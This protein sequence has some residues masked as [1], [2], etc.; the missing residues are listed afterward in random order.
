MKLQYLRAFIVLLAG[1]ITLIINIRTGR[2]ITISLLIVLIVI[3]IFY[4]IGTLS[5][6]LIQKSIDN[7]GSI[8]H[9]NSDESNNSVD[10]ED[11]E[12][13]EN[14]ESSSGDENDNDIEEEF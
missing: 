8:F 11:I 5:V 12:S 6:E 9:N 10:S 2:D 3:L 1:L 14:N 7:G 13:V 4:F